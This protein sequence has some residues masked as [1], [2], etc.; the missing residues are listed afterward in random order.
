MTEIFLFTQCSNM[1]SYD[2]PSL[3]VDSMRNEQILTND[4]VNTVQ[5]KINSNIEATVLDK[6]NP[7]MC[8]LENCTAKDAEEPT[9]CDAIGVVGV[10]ELALKGTDHDLQDF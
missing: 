9:A 8:N 7:V 5:L 6:A 10:D 3:T 1:P 4:T 2:S